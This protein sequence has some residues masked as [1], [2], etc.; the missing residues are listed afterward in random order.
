MHGGGN[1]KR[2]HKI[3]KTITLCTNN[4]TPLAILWCV[5][6]SSP[7]SKSFPQYLH[8]DGHFYLVAAVIEQLRFD[9]LSLFREMQIWFEIG[10][11]NFFLMF[12][13]VNTSC[14]EPPL[15]GSAASKSKGKVEGS[16][17]YLWLVVIA[18]LNIRGVR[19]IFY[20]WRMLQILVVDV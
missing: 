4:L 17:N 11:H 3:V 7:L 14:A 12:L 13:N 6:Q 8:L 18:L 2:L 15:I 16:R 19:N 5:S 1:Y 10:L 20:N 9:G